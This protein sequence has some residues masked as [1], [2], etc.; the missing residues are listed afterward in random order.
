[1]SH[2]AQIDIEIHDLNALQQVC[3][4]LGLE[5]VMGQQTYRWFGKHV[6]DYPLP[7]GFTADELGKCE[8]AIRIPGK[9][10]AYEI[11][12]VKRRDGRPGYQLMWDFFAGGHG[13]MEKAGPECRT[14]KREY[15]VAVA[16]R[17]AMRSGFRVMEH[18]NADGSVRLQLSK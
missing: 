1:M 11:G 15:A 5:L 12:V 7:A 9:P 18:R 16:F 4:K 3:G 14:L 8:H 2:V 10:D 13:L 6:G 17:H